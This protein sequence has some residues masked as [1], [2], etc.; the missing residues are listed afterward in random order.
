MYRVRFSPHTCSGS[1]PCR[2][3]E[4]GIRICG[5]PVF[6]VLGAGNGPAAVP[7]CVGVTLSTYVPVV[8]RA[9]RGR[10][11][12]E[13]GLLIVVGVQ[14]DEKCVRVLQI[15]IPVPLT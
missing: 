9:S 10:A 8:L 4:K 6:S 11:K 1:E 15:R 13:S 14:H 12:N 5:V 7:A 3:V 2:R